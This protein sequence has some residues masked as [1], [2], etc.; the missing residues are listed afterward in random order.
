MPAWENS[1][2]LVT[3]LPYQEAA[4]K[5]SIDNSHVATNPRQ[6]MNRA[7]ELA[8]YLPLPASAFVR[9]DLGKHLTG[10]QPLAV[11]AEKVLRVRD[12]N[13]PTY[14]RVE[15]F[16]YMPNG[17]VERHH[18]GHSRQGDMQAH[19]MRLGCTLAHLSSMRF[20][21]GGRS[22]THMLRVPEGNPPDVE[23]RI[24]C[25]G[26]HGMSPSTSTRPG[27]ST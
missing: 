12:I 8:Q 2:F 21:L 17:D 25:L 27:A 5:A 3:T 16:C 11:V 18:P 6:A 7:Y 9:F 23:A 20:R 14:V 26:K 22:S 10:S 4:F 15:F 1:E 24:V 13:R 19:V